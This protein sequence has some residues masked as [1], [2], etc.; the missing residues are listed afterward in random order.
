MKQVYK[1]GE[2]IQAEKCSQS[3]FFD[4]YESLSTAFLKIVVRLFILL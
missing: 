3:T 2:E 4:F 1:V